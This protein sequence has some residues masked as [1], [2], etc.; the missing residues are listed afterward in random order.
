VKKA[1]LLVTVFFAVP[2]ALVAAG[3]L[4]M[5]A[6]DEKID[7][8]AVKSLI[9]YWMIACCGIWLVAGVR[10]R[11]KEVL[12][13]VVS[14]AVVLGLAEIGVRVFAPTLGMMRYRGVIAS[15]TYHH[16]YPADR[17]MLRGRSI[18]RTN[19]DG[20]RSDHSR[21]EFLQ[22]K[23][24]IVVLGDSFAFGLGVSQNPMLSRL[25]FDG[26]VKHY[27]PT[28][29]LLVLDAGDIAD[30]TRY[31]QEAKRGGGEV[32]FDIRGSG[33][34]NYYGAV[35]E[36][37]R[38]ITVKI[39]DYVKYPLRARRPPGY[40]FHRF[41]L[42]VDGMTETSKYFIYRYPLEKTRPY[43]ERSLS[44]VDSIASYSNRLG[45]DFVLVVTP[46]FHHWNP[47]E[48]PNNLEKGYTLNEP[49]QYE[50]FKFFEGARVS[51]DYEIFNMLPEFSATQEFPL[52]FDND[53]HWNERG[54][55]FVA[56][57]LADYLIAS[58]IV[59]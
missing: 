11:P 42:T 9:T 55:T 31:G 40:D 29:V 57:A 24:R 50:Y 52:V 51:V 41:E 48:C 16:I 14:I 5:L 4:D 20:L 30:D 6:A 12:L 3:L 35:N 39:T 21:S 53:P 43:F 7:R 1:I 54:H 26:I 28:L 46:R 13:V 36:I 56:R 38:P 32:Y 22:Y 19:E 45:G 58:G 15:P 47:E 33:A 25:L 59:D 27:R 18:V 10:R 44:H 49:F 37:F 23:D 17:E 34:P 8:I 2:V